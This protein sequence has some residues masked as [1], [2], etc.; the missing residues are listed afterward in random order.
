MSGKD[1]AH[2]AVRRVHRRPHGPRNPRRA[3]CRVK[4]GN[5]TVAKVDHESAIESDAKPGG[6]QAG[7]RAARSRA[8]SG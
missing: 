4:M 1:K 6:A 2:V 7:G 5:P 3:T 8:S